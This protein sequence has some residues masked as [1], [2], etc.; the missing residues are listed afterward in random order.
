MR[1]AA[2]GDGD[3]VD[4]TLSNG[5]LLEQSMPL[6]GAVVCCAVLVVGAHPVAFSSKKHI[7]SVLCYVVV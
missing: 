6:C 1:T 7:C 5:C 3:G 2:A 4:P